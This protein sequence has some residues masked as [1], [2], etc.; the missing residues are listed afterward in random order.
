VDTSVVQAMRDWGAPPEDIAQAE[1]LAAEAQAAADAAA[2]CEVWPD[3][4]A[5]FAAFCSCTQW[6]HAG[7]G[8]QRV[9]LN[10]PGVVVYLDHLEH[11]PRRRRQLFDDFL[12]LERAALDAFAELS[13]KE[14]T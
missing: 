3:N 6:V 10:Y 5:S 1:A 9:G 7:M 2:D 13:E 12:V 4:W 11:H 14:S 8:G